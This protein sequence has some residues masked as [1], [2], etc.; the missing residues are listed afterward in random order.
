MLGETM[1]DLLSAVFLHVAADHSLPEGL[2]VNFL[3]PPS[4]RR[5]FRMFTQA[6]CALRLSQVDAI[7]FDLDIEVA[8]VH[9]TFFLE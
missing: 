2:S 5:L 8:T 7:V 6:T 4:I 1:I 9:I 3:L